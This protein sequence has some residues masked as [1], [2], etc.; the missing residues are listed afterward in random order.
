MPRAED[1]MPD[2]THLALALDVNDVSTWMAINVP[3]TVI[4]NDGF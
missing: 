3:L 4:H 2:S 1:C